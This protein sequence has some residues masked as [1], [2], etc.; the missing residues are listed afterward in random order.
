MVSI[1]A[2]LDQV[3]DI[4]AIFLHLIQLVVHI[5]TNSESAPRLELNSSLVRPFRI[6]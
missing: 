5:N 1:D 6:G 3:A 2:S 4:V